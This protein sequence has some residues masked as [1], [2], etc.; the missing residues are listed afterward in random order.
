MIFALRSGLVWLGQKGTGAVACSVFVGMALPQ[1]AETFRPLL[2][3]AIFAL[4]VLALVRIDFE[5]L[6]ERAGR[7]KSISW[8]VIWAMVFMPLG[9]GLILR[10]SGFAAAYP[11]LALAVYIMTAAPPVM[12]VAALAAIMRLDYALSVVM[13]VMCGLVVPFV[14]PFIAGLTLSAALPLHTVELAV[15]LGLLL[16]SAFFVAMVLRR[17]AGLDAIHRN[18]QTINGA[19]VVILFVFAVAAMDGVAV[20]FLEQ[21]Q[22]ALAILGTV[23][24]IA[25]GQMALTMLALYRVDRVQAFTIALGTGLRNMGVFVAAIGSAIPDTTYLY[26]GIGQFPIYL[27]PFFLRSVGSRLAAEKEG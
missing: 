23:F 7:W 8:A 20:A 3:S 27:L 16:S 19:N 1:L 13:L 17:L 2:P 4:L 22:L 14:A 21:T 6:R 12:S 9:I 11:D 25:F 10:F 24:A 26:F 15:R 18:D 5:A